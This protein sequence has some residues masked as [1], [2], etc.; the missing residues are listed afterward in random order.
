M[1][2]F[3]YGYFSYGKKKNIKNIRKNL[4]KKRNIINKIIA[5]DL[6]KEFYDGKRI[7]GYGGFRYDGRWKIFL[8]KIIHKYKLNKNSKVLDIGCKKGFFIKDLKDLI[9][10]IKVYGV[11]DH[12]YPIKNCLKSV[13]K[14]I[15]FVP[16]YYNLKYSKNYFDFVHALNCIY[17]YSLRD[18]VKVI[19]KINYISKQSH[20]TVPVYY[21]EKQRRKFLDWTLVGNVILKEK[22]WRLM[23]KFLNYKG[24]YYFSGAKSLGL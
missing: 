10:G 12:K 11:E 5:N 23:F 3:D 13:K 24:D 4:T 22:E 9:P 17:G 16:Y 18:L 14:D 8:K 7:N 6:D 15:K 19:K 21:N 1:S 20:V 2:H